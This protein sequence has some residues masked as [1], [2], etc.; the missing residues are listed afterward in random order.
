MNNPVTG[1]TL[2]LKSEKDQ[3]LVAASCLAVCVL[4]IL[5]NSWLSDDAY[6]TLRTSDN[7][8]HGFG[9]RWNVAER[10]QTYTH[11]LWMMLL[12]AVYSVTREAYFT[13]LFTSVAVSAAAVW[14]LFNKTARSAGGV[15][16]CAA[17]LVSSKAFVDYSTSGLEN[18]L[19]NI[20]LVLTIISAGKEGDEAWKKVCLLAALSAL[21]RMDAILY[22][23]PLL[24][25]MFFQH[26]GGWRKAFREG[27]ISFLPFLLWLVF[28]TVY[29]GFPFPNTAYAKLNNFIPRAELFIQG[30]RYL[31]NSFLIDPVTLGASLILLI[32]VFFRGNGR[33]KSLAC[34]ALL[35]IFYVVWIGGDF[36]SGRFLSGSF[37]LMAAL[38]TSLDFGG[39]IGKKPRRYSVYLSASIIIAG[40]LAPLPPLLTGPAYR[41][42]SSE[43]ITDDYNISDEKGGYWW[44]CSLQRVLLDKGWREEGLIFPSPY[45][46]VGRAMIK[47]GKTVRVD[48]VAGVLGYYA[49]PTAYII[50]FVALCDPFLSRLAYPPQPFWR[51]GH[52]D[53]LLPVG[54]MES[55]VSGKNEILD[56]RL[57]EFYDRLNIVTRG[58]IFSAERFTE[59]F[60]INTGYYRQATDRWDYPH[61]HPFD[62][63]RLT[64]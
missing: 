2:S 32:L 41:A 34:G 44:Y 38:G 61:V 1:E 48:R 45:A 50:D 29:Y 20:L 51:P 30:L 33:A 46:G 19:T 7:F 22:F 21:N 27:L 4:V 24:G 12:T 37:F 10:V 49:G 28:S 63:N 17:L 47:N 15:L 8:I 59:I 11:P 60:R 25:M 31:E 62:C 42:G 64:W 13:T 57:S 43:E 18:P 39:Y 54:Y 56:E 16:I 5:Q 14:F 23:L 52:L 40:L 3:R 26:G 58:A 55:V 36:M 35:Y 6:I 9:L 53:R